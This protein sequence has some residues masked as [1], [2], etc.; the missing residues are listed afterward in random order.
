MPSVFVVIKIHIKRIFLRSF[1]FIEGHGGRATTLVSSEATTQ[2]HGL[3]SLNPWNVCLPI[4]KAG[5]G[6]HSLVQGTF[7]TQGLN[8]VSCTAGGL[9]T[10]WD[11]REGLMDQRMKLISQL[12]IRKMKN[13]QYFLILRHFIYLAS[14]KKQ[15]VTAIPSVGFYSQELRMNI[16]LKNGF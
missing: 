13:Q 11:T 16:F 12:Q 4:L 8:P 1:M 10:S 5:V 6:S 14:I 9:F 2:Y 15:V 3:G 7:P